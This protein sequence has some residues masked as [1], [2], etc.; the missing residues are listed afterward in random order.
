MIDRTPWRNPKVLGLLA[1]VFLCGGICGSILTR[2][3]VAPKQKPAP[4]SEANTSQIR[5]RLKNEL[6]LTP[7]QQER[8]NSILEDYSKFYG[9]LHEQFSEI[10]MQMDDVRASGK[11]RIMNVLDESQKR[12][13]EQ[14]F[15]ESRSRK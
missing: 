7:E 14:M 6:Q 13:F 12:K 10:Q 8:I 11:A 9:S 1:L 4:L 5:E 15:A 3:V 2:A